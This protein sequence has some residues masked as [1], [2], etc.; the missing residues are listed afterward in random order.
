MSKGTPG[1]LLGK[2]LTMLVHVLADTEFFAQLQG[3]RYDCNR[4]EWD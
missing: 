1:L 2:L 3:A 4:L